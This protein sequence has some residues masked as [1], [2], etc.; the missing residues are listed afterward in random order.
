MVATHLPSVAS[1]ETGG[2]LLV[3]QL[4]ITHN[5][6]DLKKEFL[7]SMLMTLRGQHNCASFTMRFCTHCAHMQVTVWTESTSVF[8]VPDK[9]TLFC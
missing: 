6:Y 7:S 3:T 1:S 8:D 9:N 4:L 5:Q 2:Q